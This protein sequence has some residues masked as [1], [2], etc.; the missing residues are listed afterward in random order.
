MEASDI[1]GEG[2]KPS[3]LI[4]LLGVKVPAGRR[5]KRR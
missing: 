1:D 2:T 3:A 5:G 4:G